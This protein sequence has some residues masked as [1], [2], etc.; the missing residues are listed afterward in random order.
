M[1]CEELQD[2]HGTPN[3]NAHF[4]MSSLKVT[5]QVIFIGIINWD[6]INA[7][8]AII[9]N[10]GSYHKLGQYS[11][12]YTTVIISNLKWLV[13]VKIIFAGGRKNPD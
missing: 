11:T 13:F 3:K 8:G 9:R 10:W 6:R 1:F 4:C 2:V 7:I 12:I 5:W